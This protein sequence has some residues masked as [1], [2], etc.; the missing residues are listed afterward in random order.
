MTS[1]AP[2]PDPLS[3][4][5]LAALADWRHLLHRHPEL[6]GAEAA[7]AARVVEALTPTGPDR[8]LTGLGGHGVA[9]VYDGAAPGPAVMLRAEL[10]ALPIEEVGTPPYRSETPGTAHLCGHDGHITI[11]AGVARWLGQNRPARGRAILLF[12]PAEEDG[13]GAARVIADPQFAEIRPD[14]ALSLHNMPGVPLG[15]ARLAPG[16]MNCASR[17]MTMGRPVRTAA[18]ASYTCRRSSR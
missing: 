7:T 1:A 3:P 6:S 18:A 5:D 8:L 12:Q 16:I 9:S 17:G 15:Q 2:L 13:A 4:A 11:L 10:D 14:I